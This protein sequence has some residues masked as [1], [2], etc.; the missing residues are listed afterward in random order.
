MSAHYR[1]ARSAPQH[2]IATD[3]RLFLLV[4]SGAIPVAMLLIWA[5]IDSRL[6]LIAKAAVAFVCLLWILIVASAVRGEL[7]RHIRTLSNLVESIRVQDYS[8]RGSR[9]REPGELAELYQQ[10]NILTES[11]KSSRQGEQELLS[12][13]EKVVSQINVAII[14]CDSRDKIRLVNQLATALLKTSAEKLVG[15][16][17]GDTALVGLPMSP[18]PKLIDF[19]FPGAEG[20]W[21]VSQHNYRHEGKTS[22][23]VFVADLKQVLSE[24][25]IA[26]WQRLIRVISHEVN[27]S[28]TPITS[29]CQTLSSIASK[30]E[31]AELKDDIL[32]GLDVIAERAKGLQEF[33][34]VYA[35]LARLP[36]PHKVL[37]PVVELAGNLQRIFANQPLTILPFPDVTVFGDPVHL[38]QA[39]INLIKN[40]LEANPAAAPDVQLTCQLRGG[41]CEFQITDNGSG[42]SNP[43][44]LFVPF[45]TTKKEGAGIGLILCRQ[46]AAKHHGYVSLE[47]RTDASGAGAKLVLPLPPAS[48]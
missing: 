10:L 44:N 22:R 29:L 11:L 19:R 15:I 37:F 18:E 34:S 43:G 31:S 38:E 35:R 32:E 3:W 41:Q 1:S 4:L 23:I 36:E 24:E 30:P 28:L 26:A 47:N 45:Y 40:G 20:R 17:F 21:Q 12:I 39:L 46:I 2:R 14:V 25:E 8:M 42:I 27:N 13:L 33:I 16:N 7:L 9:A 6:P 48:S 5:S